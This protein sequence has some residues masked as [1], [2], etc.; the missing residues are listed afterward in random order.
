M[1]FKKFWQYAVY[2]SMLSLLTVVLSVFGGSRKGEPS[3]T[4]T[5]GNPL[6]APVA[7]ADIPGQTNPYDYSNNGDTGSD[8]DGGDCDGS[9]DCDGM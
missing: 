8:S 1:R 6:N 9:G 2:G 4:H 7:Q 3:Y 5:S